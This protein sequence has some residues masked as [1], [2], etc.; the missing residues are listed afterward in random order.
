M[1]TGEQWHVALI[2]ELRSQRQ[3]DLRIRG[4]PGLQSKFQDSQDY[5]EKLFLEK[6]TNKQRKEGRKGKNEGRKE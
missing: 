5:T 4:L 1:Y 2:P 3:A 6:Q